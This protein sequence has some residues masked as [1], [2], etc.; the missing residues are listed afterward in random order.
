MVVREFK[1]VNEKGEE[2][3]LMKWDNYCFLRFKYI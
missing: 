1:L 2:Y 3:S